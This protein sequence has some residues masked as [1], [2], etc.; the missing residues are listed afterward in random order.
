MRI[1]RL[2]AVEKRNDTICFC[3]I[4][5]NTWFI[6][7]TTSFGSL[8]SSFP[9]SLQKLMDYICRAVLILHALLVEISDSIQSFSYGASFVCQG[10]AQ[11]SRIHIISVDEK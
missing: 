5:N 3:I 10:I 11:S 9:K 1:L 6:N 8:A 4:V 2:A 7:E